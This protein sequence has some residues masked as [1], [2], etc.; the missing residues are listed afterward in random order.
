MKF[1]CVLRHYVIIFYYRLIIQY[2]YLNV[3]HIYDYILMRKL[4]DNVEVQFK[5]D[6]EIDTCEELTNAACMMKE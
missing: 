3:L 1:N 6:V 2:I 5:R 4:L